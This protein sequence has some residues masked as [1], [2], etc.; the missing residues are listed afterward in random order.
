MN[1]RL[2]ITALTLPISLF[3]PAVANAHPIKGVGDFYAGMLHPITAIEYAVP[4]IAIG[5]CAGQ[6]SRE[7]A[8]DMVVAFPIACGLGALLAFIVAVPGK[9]AVI[10]Y[11]CMVVLG[12]LVALARRMPSAI[13]IVLTASVG[14]MIG[15]DNGAEITAEISPYRFI[16]GLVFSSLL[17]IVYGVGLVR[18]LKVPWTLFAV[19][20][21]GS[22]IAALGI[23]VSGIR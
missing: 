19:R 10:D 20:V 17:S 16:P 14:V 7:T 6:Q 9:L 11:G 13:A 21:V 18:H 22:W 4:L 3:A 8:R 2:F 5:L 12:V 1:R 15:W 23:L